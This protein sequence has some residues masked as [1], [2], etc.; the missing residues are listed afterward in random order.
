MGENIIYY[1]PPGTGK[2]FLLQQLKSHYLGFNISIEEINKAYVNTSKD[3][4]LV[5][6]VLLQ[7]DNLMTSDKIQEKVEEILNKPFETG[8]STVLN[9][10]STFLSQMFTHVEP[11]IFMQQEEKWYVKLDKLRTYD[12]NFLSEHLTENSI[13]ERFKFVTFHQS[14]VYEDF[15]EG[16]RPL[17]T[18]NTEDLTSG[19]IRYSIEPGVFKIICEEA[20]NNPHKNY[21]IFIDEIN[22]GNISEIFG[23]LITLIEVDKRIGE[24]NQLE[25]NLPYSKKKFGVPNNLDIIGTMN[26][27]DRSIA[28]IDIA[29]RRRFQ[30]IERNPD[31][32]LLTD[33]LK[34]ANVDSRDIEGVDLIMFLENINKRIEVLL[35]STFAIGHAYFTHV[36]SFSDLKNVLV[37]QL[38][39]LLEEYFFD[40]Y[41]KIQIVFNDL[42]ENG[43][44]KNNAIYHH[45]DIDI[46]NL[47]DYVGEYVHEAKSS[48][49]AGTNIDKSSLIKVYSK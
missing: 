7:G 35:D 15:V 10:H 48:Y 30:F 34:K 40:D 31:L 44:A 16:I 4:V 9:N 20:K 17:I 45:Y 37:N 27:A 36:K 6:L 26:S 25:V 14:F 22:R 33:I 13:E 49:L 2:T 38:I 28:L 5:A 43:E 18:E 47:F 1:G 46:N 11:Q 39:P 8:V 32:S 29:L 23:E 19:D 41:K 12:N 3:W 21:A 42:D 24:A